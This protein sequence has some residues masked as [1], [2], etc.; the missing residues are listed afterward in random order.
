MNQ[1]ESGKISGMTAEEI[2]DCHPQ[3]QLYDLTKFKTYNKTRKNM[4]AKRMVMITEEEASFK[5][6]M[7]CFP[8]KSET[9]RG[10]PLWYNHKANEFL[11]NHITK[12]I[13]G[14]TSN[15]KPQELWKSRAEYQEFPRSVF[16]KHILLMLLHSSKQT[17]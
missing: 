3:F 6:D 9:G 10:I 4:T 17:I 1:N 12:E 2:W 13:D 14:T 7:I 16:Q 8:K 11:Q 5:K 15:I